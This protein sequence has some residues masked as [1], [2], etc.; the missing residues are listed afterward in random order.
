MCGGERDREPTGSRRGLKAWALWVL[1]SALGG[2]VGGA[3][4]VLEFLGPILLWGVALGVAQALVLW[5]YL[6][7]AVGPWVAISS[8][9]WILG[10]VVFL[11]VRV[12]VDLTGVPEI[13]RRAGSVID[14]LAGSVDASPTLPGLLVVWVVFAASQGMVL[15]LVGLAA[16]RRFCC[17][18]LPSG[19]S[20]APWAGC[21]P[22][23]RA[24]T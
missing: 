4:T 12:L 5:R 13:A 24:T 10:W 23:P 15:A 2:A 22:W 19:C 14:R 3:A 1:A 9:G 16:G 8:V 21:R 6:R 7:E 11:L 18:W 20:L 17:P